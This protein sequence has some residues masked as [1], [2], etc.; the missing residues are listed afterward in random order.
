MAK[1]STGD[2]KKARALEFADISGNSDTHF[3]DFF[4]H[5]CW[6]HVLK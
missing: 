5:S 3:T 6:F 1:F 2:S 4:F